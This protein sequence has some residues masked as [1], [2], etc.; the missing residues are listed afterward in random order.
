[1]RLQVKLE[2][3][4]DLMYKDEK[5]EFTEDLQAPMLTLREKLKW[6][7]TNATQKVKESVKYKRLKLRVDNM[8][9]LETQ[10]EIIH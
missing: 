5:T 4:K 1:M 3:L 7:E 10:I 9:E 2:T 6:I 8:N